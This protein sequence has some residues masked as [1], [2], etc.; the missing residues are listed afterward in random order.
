MHRIDFNHISDKYRMFFDKG[1]EGEGALLHQEEQVMR[2]ADQFGASVQSPN[3]R[4]T[5]SLFAKR[6]N[7]LL[8]GALYLW[9]FHGFGTDLSRDVIKIRLNGISLIFH[10][11]GERSFSGW[12]DEEY[13]RHMMIDNA[14]PVFRLIASHTTIPEKNLW[15]HLSY[16]LAYWNQEW[17]RNELSDVL[18][19]RIEDVYLELAKTYSLGSGFHACEDPL[20]TEHAILVRDTCCMNYRLQGEDRYCYT[21]PLITD[22]RR[23]EKYRNAHQKEQALPEIAA[24]KIKECAKV[25]SI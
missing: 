2:L 10:L 18:R 24:D 20:H 23:W 3:R 12:T 25:A 17:L 11:Y 14:A 21:C 6:Y 22:E 19:N 13:I 8:A 1:T 5:G 15:S 4:V 16:L 9:L 7:S